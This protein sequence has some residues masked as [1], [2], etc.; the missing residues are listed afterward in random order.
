MLTGIVGVYRN[1]RGAFGD[2]VALADCNSELVEFFGN[3]WVERGTTADYLAEPAAECR[4]DVRKQDSAQIN[5]NPSQPGGGSKRR[6]ENFVLFLLFCFFPDFLVHG[7]DKERDKNQA[8]RTEEAEV[9]EHALERIVYTYIHSVVERRHHAAQLIG[10]VY[11]QY[12]HN[13]IL[14]E[15][16]YA[17]AGGVHAGYKILF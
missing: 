6:P 14:G 7:V 9:F 13:G 1:E 12:R 2:A 4:N 10:V 8:G 11:R 5:A 16:F 15:K 17:L 3:L